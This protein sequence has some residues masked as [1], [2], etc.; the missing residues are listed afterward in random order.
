MPAIQYYVKHRP[1]KRSCQHANAAYR[2]IVGRNMLRAFG[3]R[4]VLFQGSSLKMAN[5]EPKT[6]NMQ[7]QGGQTR[8]QFLRFLSE[9]FS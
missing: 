1:A 4:V 7:Q 5:Y 9:K 6:P 8:Q 3:H 2:K